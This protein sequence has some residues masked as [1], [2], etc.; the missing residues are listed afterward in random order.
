MTAIGQGVILG[1]GEGRR[2][3]VALDTLTFKGAGEADRFTVVEYEAAAGM[4]GPP[5]H[6]HHANEEAF[7]IL[8]GELD[9][10]LEGE[11]V[12]LRRGAFALV[13]RGAAHT[14][15]NAGSGA[16]RWIGIFAPGHYEQLVEELG[17]LLPQD[18][19]PDPDVVAALFAKWETEI[20][21]QVQ[22]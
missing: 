2:V 6:I 13:P 15:A 14:F 20:V 9:F 17:A 11:T 7:Y 4:P 3:G 18:S 22:S 21:A 12:R 8:D 1:A 19:P 5:P 10:M 16:A